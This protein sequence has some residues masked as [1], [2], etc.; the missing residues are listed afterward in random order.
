MS[1]ISGVW[2]R[3]ILDSRGCPTVEVE[4]A[5]ND[6]STGRAAVPSGASTGAHE[7]IELRDGDS[8]RYFGKGVQRAVASV[9]VEIAKEV[10]GLDATCQDEVDYAMIRLDGSPNKRNLGANAIL[11]VSMATAKAAANHF[12]MPLYRYLG[13]ASAKLL[14]VPLM[15][16]I[17][18]GKHA[19]NPIDIQEFMIVPLAAKSFRHALRMGAE[20]FNSLKSGLSDAGLSI[21]VGDEG[22]FAPE[23]E[24]TRVAMDFVMKSIEDAGYTPGSDVF[25]ALDCASSEYFKDGQYCLDGEK[26]V[27]STEENIDYLANLVRD[28]PVYSIEDGCAED[29]WEGWSLMTKELGDKCY[30]IGDDFF[31]T[32]PKRFAEGIRSAS[33][34]A[35]LVK[36]NQIGTVSETLTI[37]EMAR[38][39][40]FAAVMSHRSGETEDTTIADMA[41]GSNCGLIKTGSLSRSDRTAKYNQLLRIEEELGDAA[42]YP[43]SNSIFGNLKE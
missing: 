25:L 39:S 8:D 37:F 35:I 24:S 16:I 22:G 27:L 4:V 36:P 6:G 20:I 12:G 13:G 31:A 42:V 1:K 19:D 32:N 38:K 33:A 26:K 41:V 21:A 10:V 18:G 15:N 3:E 43:G 11:G 14:P 29:D 7:A 23:I 34:N 9:K 30:L 40:N 5:L 28:Y 2:A 17:N